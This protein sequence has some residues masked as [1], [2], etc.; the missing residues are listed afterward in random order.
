LNE[1]RRFS[2]I[3]TADFILIIL[4]HYRNKFYQFNYGF[5]S[6]EVRRK[7]GENQLV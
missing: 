6:A 5:G 4:V 3:I 2:A 7:K 1:E